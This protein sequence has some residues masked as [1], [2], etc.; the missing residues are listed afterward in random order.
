MTMEVI[1]ATAFGRTVDVQ[2]GKGGKL[3]E[4]AK[5]MFRGLDSGAGPVISTIVM[6]SSMYCV[7]THTCMVWDMETCM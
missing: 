2:G 6:L 5:S 7:C 3:Y 4:N 1:L